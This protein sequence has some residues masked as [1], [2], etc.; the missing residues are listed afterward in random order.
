MFGLDVSLTTLLAAHSL[1][2]DQVDSQASLQDD[3]SAI[4]SMQ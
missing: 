1:I 2:C 3:D 4:G